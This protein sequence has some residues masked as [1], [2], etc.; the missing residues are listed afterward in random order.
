MVE[1][2]EHL[3]VPTDPCY[4]P[5]GVA[6]HGGLRPSHQKSTRLH[7]IWLRVLR[8]AKLLTPPLKFMGGEPLVLHRVQ[9]DER[10]FHPDEYS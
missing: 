6:P 10:G 2:Y 4:C 1:R 3:A 7:A 9:S 8:G 5:K